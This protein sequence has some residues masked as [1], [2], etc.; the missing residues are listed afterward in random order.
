MQYLHQCVFLDSTSRS[1]AEGIIHRNF[2]LESVLL[3]D[4]Y[5]YCKLTD[6]RESRIMSADNCAMTVVGNSYYMAPEIFRGERYDKKVDV[7][8]FGISLVE[9]CQ[10]GSVEELLIARVKSE[11]GSQGSDGG[12]L[13]KKLFKLLHDDAIRPLIPDDSDI[14]DSLRTSMKDCW[15]GKSSNRPDFGEIVRR[16]EADVEAEVEPDFR[17]PQVSDLDGEF[18]ERK[19]AQDRLRERMDKFQSIKG[20]S[21][22]AA[23]SSTAGLGIVPRRISV[24]PEDAEAGDVDEQIAKIEKEIS[25][26]EGVIGSLEGE[27]VKQLRGNMAVLKETKVLEAE[28]KKMS[29]KHDA[30]R[31]EA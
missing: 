30:L 12:V 3:T 13:D 22:A 18:H 16:L 31:A 29:A 7:Y 9:F 11:T 14:P 10:M 2:S 17:K 4:N 6:F 8:S 15:Q 5:R 20:V 27:L 24:I 21:P 25:D 23:E 1:Y 28:F 26:K 19:L